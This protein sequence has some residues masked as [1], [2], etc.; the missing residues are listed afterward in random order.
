M[1]TPAEIEAQVDAT[2]ALIGLPLAAAHRP[3]V[4]HYFALAA[5]MAERVM[6]HPLTPEDEPAA[7]FVP[8]SPPAPDGRT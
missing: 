7:L 3:G 8:V 1:S 6:A 5:G 4:L 2:A